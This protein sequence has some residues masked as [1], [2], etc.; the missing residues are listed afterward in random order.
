MKRLLALPLAL[1]LGCSTVSKQDAC[2]AAQS[3][4]AI[5]LA[6]INAE[7]TPSKD[8]IL[9]A[10]AAAAVLQSQ[11]GWAAPVQTRSLNPA[12][13]SDAYGVPVLLPPR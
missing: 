6:V 8:Q 2:T 12:V 1:V 5:Y 7:G 9:A 4:Y 10:T 3:A 13:R 11:C